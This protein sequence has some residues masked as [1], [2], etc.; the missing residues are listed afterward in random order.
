MSACSSFGRMLCER[1]QILGWTGDVIPAI[2][3]DCCFQI[4]DSR[5]DAAHYG[6]CERSTL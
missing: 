6:S 4:E 3:K 2:L 5:T 1:G